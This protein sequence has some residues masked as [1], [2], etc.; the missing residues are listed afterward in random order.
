MSSAE[1][2]RQKDRKLENAIEGLDMRGGAS[3][4]SLFGDFLDLQLSFFC[5]NPDSRQQQLYAHMR[6]DDGYRCAMVRAMEAYGDAAEDFHDPLGE[7]FMKRISGGHNGQFFT[8]EN[9]CL[10]MARITEPLQDSVSDTARR[11]GWNRRLTDYG[12]A[13]TLRQILSSPH[14]ETVVKAGRYDIIEGVNYEHINSLWPQL[15]MIIRHNYRPKDMYTWKDTIALAAA[16]GMDNMSM[17][18]VC[19]D[20]L[21]AIHDTLCRINR[22]R[23]Q[24]KEVERMKSGDSRF[25]RHYG[26]LLNVAISESGIDIRPLQGAEEFVDEG[27]AMHHCVATYYN[28]TDNLILTAR[29]DGIRL[30]TIELDLDD[31]HVVQCRGRHNTVPKRYDDIIAII[32]KN[33]NLF[34]I[35]K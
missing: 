14:F 5:N 7:M 29:A 18:Y 13:K 2:T 34:R 31:L 15:K 33:K 20:D 22:R 28:N 9:I 3:F 26:Q 19:P 24:G 30:A 4:N 25:R 1:L 11:N 12:T 8:P 23:L 21:T 10:F 17:K 35:N 27:N 32:E 16:N 6:S